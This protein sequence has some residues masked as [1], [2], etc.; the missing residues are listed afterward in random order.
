MENRLYCYHHNYA[1]SLECHISNPSGNKIDTINKISTID[2]ISKS[3][4][5]TI[6]DNY[7]DVEMI[8]RFKGYAIFSAKQDVKNI[9]NG[10]YNSV[11]D[12]AED[13]RGR[14]I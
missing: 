7:N 9:A 12:L 13:I 10:E 1:N 5:Y 14:R 2:K 8:K 11:A 4:I 3:S 6:G